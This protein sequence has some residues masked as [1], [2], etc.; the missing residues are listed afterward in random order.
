[1]NL[2]KRM[3]G[4]QFKLND[5]AFENYSNSGY[6]IYQH[7]LTLNYRICV[8]QSEHNFIFQTTDFTQI[9]DFFNN[10]YLEK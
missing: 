9:N 8:N 3:E 10:L 1:M 2:W 4:V 7:K 6:Y 5:K